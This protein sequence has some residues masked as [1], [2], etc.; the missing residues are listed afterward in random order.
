MF[1]RQK[2]KAVANITADNPSG[3]IGV[4]PSPSEFS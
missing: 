4:Q 2:S 1:T 3:G